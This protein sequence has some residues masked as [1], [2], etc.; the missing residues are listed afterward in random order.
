MKDHII[1]ILLLMSCIFGASGAAPEFSDPDFAYPQDVIKNARKN[2]DA[3]RDPLRCLL[4]IT[5]AERSIDPDTIYSLPALV[6]DQIAKST[7]DAS[8]ALL[9]AYEAEIYTSI[10]KN[11]RWKYNEVDAPLMPLP[12]DISKWS[13]A[14][15]AYKINELYDKALALAK[16]DN[17]PLTDYKAAIEYGKET[18]DYIPDIYGFILSRRIS[19]LENFRVAGLSD[20]KALQE[21]CDKLAATYA[22][23]SDPAV[24]WTCRRIAIGNSRASG[25][26]Y[27]EVYKANEGKPGAPYALS[28]ALDMGLGSFDPEANATDDERAGQIAVRDSIIAILKNAIKTYPTFYQRASFENHLKSLA[29]PT[30]AYSIPDMAAPGSTIEVKVRYSF[31][32]SVG[33]GLYKL[34]SGDTRMSASRITSTLP[35]IAKKN[36]PT[37]ATDGKETLTFTL[38]EPGR[39]A[40]VPMINGA[41]QKNADVVNIICTPFIPLNINGCTTNAVIAADYVTGAPVQ[42]VIVDY[43]KAGRGNSYAK[44]YLGKT[45][46]SGILAYSVPDENRYWGSYMRFTYKN[47]IY[48]FDRSIRANAYNAKDDEDETAAY[49]VNV[50]TDRNL[51]HPGDSIAWVVAVAVREPGQKPTVASDK[52]LMIKLQDAN[53]ENIDTINVTT[54]ALGR[55]SGTFA[56]QKGTLTG[57]YRILVQDPDGR[58]SF[59]SAYVMVSDF[60]LPTFEAEFTSVERDIPSA[61]AVRLTGKARTYSGM[62]V[63]GA[64]VT[65]KVVGANRWRW[66]MPT[67]EEIAQLEAT[68][69]AAGVFVVDV[70]ASDLAKTNTSGNKFDS[71]QATA[72]ITSVTAETSECSKNFTTGKPYVLAAKI[73]RRVADSSSPLAVSFAAYNADGDNKPIAIGWQL[74]SGEKPVL[75]GSTKGGDRENIDVSSLDAGN[76][77]LRLFP[78]DR[79]LADTLDNAASVT[80]YNVKRNLVPPGEKLFVPVEEYTVSG[81]KAEVVVG[82]DC[83]EVYVYCAMQLGD[84]LVTF[85]PHKVSRGFDRI[86]FELPQTHKKADVYLF[87]VVEGRVSNSTVV[88]SRPEDKA[89]EIIAESFRDRLVPGAPETW[90]FRLVDGKGKGIADAAMVATM[91]NK[92][93]DQLRN[94]SFATLFHFYESHANMSL[95]YRGQSIDNGSDNIQFRWI[96]VPQYNWPEYMFWNSNTLYGI[97]IRGSR[98]MAMKSAATMDMSDGV[99]LEESAVVEDVAYNSAASQMLAGATA[100][101]EAEEKAED[102]DSGEAAQEQKFDYRP[103]EVLQAFWRPS[104]VTDAEG[105]VD[106]VF[107]VPNAN[108]TWQFKASAWTRDLVTAQFDTEALANKPVMVQ[109]NLPRF[110]RQGDK[111]TVLATVFNNSTDTVTVTTTVELFDVN[112]DKVVDSRSFDNVIAPE[113]SAVVAM[114][115]EAGTDKDAIGYRV[116]SV[117]GSFADGEQTVIPVL[118]AASTVI[119][120]TEFYLNPTDK[121]PFTF[122]VKASDDASVT[123]QYCQNPV[124]TVVKAM[125]GISGRNESTAN[126]LVGQLFSALS[127]KYIV[128]HNPAI[129]S[130]IK[131]WSENPSEEALV[132]MLEKNEDLKR[133]LLD[134]TP[135]VQ[136]AASNTR[137]MAALADLLD[138]AKADAAVTATVA[139]LAKLQNTDGGFRWGGWSDASSEWTTRTVLMT[140]GLANS[141]HMIPA[142]ATDILAMIQPAFSYVEKEAVKP[143][144]PTTDNEL[145]LI[146]TLF[147]TVK[148]STAGDRL[149][150]NSVAGI[151]RNWREDGTVGKAYDIIVLAGNGRKSEAERV[152]ASLR[153]FGV[154]KAGMGLT[155]PSVSDIRA[156]ATIIQAYV[157]MGA[158]AADIDAMRQWVIV[159]AQANDDLGAYIP[160]YIIAAVLLTGSDWTSVPVAQNVTVNGKPLVISSEESAT[161]YFSQ[162]LDGKGK[163]KITVTP[164]GST[165]SYGSV[166]T[167]DNRPMETVK[168]RPGRD[169]A[170]D[171]RVLVERDGQWVETNDFA[172]GERVRVQLTIVA[173]RNLEYISIDDERP[174]CFEP[175]DQLPGYVYGGGLGFYRENL[176]AS[177]RLFI[178]YLP[179]GTYHLTYDMTANLAGSFISGIATLQSQYAPELTAHSSAARITV[180]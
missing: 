179:Q 90:R 87:T 33:F 65:V 180:E 26:D 98:K 12:D 132:S 81:T 5:V 73:S 173:K 116:R 77:A 63:A 55:V 38:T 155:F 70:P 6:E 40:L 85:E 3:G 21:A 170:I 2:L 36:A 35:C 160:D 142:G 10:Y 17:K 18:L 107:T 16:A 140:L 158:P 68:T 150:R 46:R 172:L 141:L 28:L 11:N 66:F 74:I 167:I 151:A 64:K 145:A 168:A 43:M 20:S 157:A 50:L 164:N 100:G 108:T 24:Y 111:A 80:L 114:P 166:V 106:I 125:R 94:G 163:F 147:P 83:K 146:A 30:M 1:A 57:N 165:P 19:N 13:A 122:T 34:P 42:G 109:P 105:N 8:R 75:S 60:K 41:V 104:L 169:L 113:A 61:G 120:S 54:D 86:K 176:D 56:T 148:K 39:Y 159:Q 118:S 143:K 49:V 128:E 139:A 69:D 9:T 129:A 126:G 22:A 152:F 171:K 48:E 127:A 27:L 76:Y 52:K 102:E 67:G 162:R 123:L 99:V 178:G 31:T 121:D 84:D 138:P 71:F 53:Y 44:N 175:V 156:Y 47:H 82:T 32:R 115:L 134:Q 133:L 88:L 15:F 112:T 96:D 149:I 174:A 97:Y 62:P 110:M 58:E 29:E 153:E 101:V 59:G 72:V 137:R 78:T 37:D 103:A 91:Y 117:A 45:G 136:A 124:W 95:A 14:Q 89:P 144:R 131:H 177:T 25:R 23:G 92:A 93:L 7:S 4:E 79:A 135:W 119:E 51:Y 154:V 130:A 161:G